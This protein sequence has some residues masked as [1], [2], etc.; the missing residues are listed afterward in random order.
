MNKMNKKSHDTVAFLE[1]NLE[2]CL[3]Q[4]KH[5]E[6]SL[7][8]VQRLLK[9][10]KG[11]PTQLTSEEQKNLDVF[12]FRFSR[13]QDILG[14]KVF[15]GLVRA[16]LEQAE[17]MLDVMHKMEKYGVLDNTDDWRRIRDTRND[18]THDYALETQ[19]VVAKIQELVAFTP[20][21]LSVT[22]RALLYAKDKLK[23]DLSENEGKHD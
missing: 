2:T 16:T 8:D 9:E 7:K 10:H 13:L 1:Y 14:G 19:D 22:D 17:S 12:L 23:I 4:K 15:R 20:E 6:L 3:R 11:L 21:L 5:L 18:V